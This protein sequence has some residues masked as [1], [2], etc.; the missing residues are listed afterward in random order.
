MAE[1]RIHK[2]PEKK[3]YAKV[4]N[5]AARDPRLSFGAIGLL[6]HLLSMPPNH[7]VLKKSIIKNQKVTRTMLDNFFMELEKYGYIVV[8]NQDTE[9]GKFSGLDYNVFSTPFNQTERAFHEPFFHPDLEEPP[10][11]SPDIGPMQFADIEQNV[12]KTPIV[13]EKAAEHGEFPDVGNQQ[14]PMQSPDIEGAVSP[15]SNK[16]E[17]YKT[18]TASQVLKIVYDLRIEFTPDPDAQKRIRIPAETASRV[19]M[20]RSREKEFYQAFGKDKTFV[21][22]VEW[23]FR[24]KAMEWSGDAM[25]WKYFDP[26]TLLNSENF[27]KY[28]EACKR[29]NGIPPK[30][31][32]KTLPVIPTVASSPESYH[33]TPR[34]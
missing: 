32:D 17:I 11:Q 9:K 6:T 10:M 33:T 19:S 3:Y 27:I 34:T 28:C 29:D 4:P 13:G 15:Y 23:V 14:R 21:K 30:K 1:V 24:Y 25:M 31:A 18:S 5:Y 8:R 16:K 12:S 2:F 20:V 7:V 26:E 22:A